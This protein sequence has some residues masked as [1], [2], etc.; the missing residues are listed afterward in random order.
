MRPV[1][2]QPGPESSFCLSRVTLG[3]FISSCACPLFCGPDGDSAHLMQR[4]GGFPREVPTRGLG[5]QQALHCDSC[6]GDTAKGSHYEEGPARHLR[7][8]WEDQQLP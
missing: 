8:T 3:K 1:R 6:D 2:G 7:F 5:A 4:W